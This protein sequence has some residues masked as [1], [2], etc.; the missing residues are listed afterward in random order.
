LDGDGDEDVLSASSG[1]DKIAWYEN[2]GSGS[3]GP[4]QVISTLATYPRS[5]YAT[6]LD[7]DGDADVLAASHGDDKIVWYENQGGGSFGF[8]QVV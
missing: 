1:D 4:Q 5:E 6:D 8:E 7:G 3:F 2:L